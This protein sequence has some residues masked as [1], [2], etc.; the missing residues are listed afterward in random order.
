LTQGKAGNEAKKTHNDLVNPVWTI[1]YRTTGRG[2][3]QTIRKTGPLPVRRKNKGGVAPDELG[4]GT[5]NV[6]PKGERW[7]KRR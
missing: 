6:L 3:K 2:G 5:G 4:G 1:D 7:S